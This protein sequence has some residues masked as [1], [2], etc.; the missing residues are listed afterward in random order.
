MEQELKQL[1]KK[2]DELKKEIKQF[3]K[4]I[5]PISSPPKIKQIFMWSVLLPNGK[6][7]THK[8]KNL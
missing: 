7:Y 2:I 3:K 8:F 4:A 5:N 6:F 1:H